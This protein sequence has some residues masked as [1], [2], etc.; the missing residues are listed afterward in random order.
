MARIEAG[1]FL[2]GSPPSETCRETD[3]VQHQVTITA[4][5][6]MA[7]TE[8]TQTQYAA[9]TGNNPALFQDKGRDY[10]V[11]QVTWRDA[12]NFCNLLSEREGL[13]P[14]YRPQGETVVWDH[15][16]D[17]YRLPTEAEWEYACRAGSAGTFHTGDATDGCARDSVSSALEQAGWYWANS[18]EVTHAVAQKKPNTWGLY[19]MHGNVWE[20][21]WDWWAP[22]PRGN[23]AD[24]RGPMAGRDRVMRGGAG[25]AGP[26]QCRA[27]YRAPTSPGREYG[28]IGFRPVRGAKT[29][30]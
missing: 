21:C 12:V 8:I 6:L 18:G 22:Y 3:E 7:V 1:T 19:D 10:P 13:T 15:S 30:S 16:A 2:M 24:P 5:F 26:D 9:V 29:G 17:G 4:P 25:N 23:T 14:C 27:A 28:F 11:E 20:W